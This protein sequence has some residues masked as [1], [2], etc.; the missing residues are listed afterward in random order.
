MV[1]I[2]LAPSFGGAKRGVCF[3]N[4]LSPLNANRDVPP[5]VDFLV[6]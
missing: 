3:C 1:V 6:I 4:F 5:R 2:P